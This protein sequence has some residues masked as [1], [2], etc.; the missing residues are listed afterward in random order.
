MNSLEVSLEISLEISLR[1]CLSWK[2]L[3]GVAPGM[4]LM[5]LQELSWNFSQEFFRDFSWSSFWDWGLKEDLLIFLMKLLPRF[6]KDVPDFSKYL[7]L[8]FVS[9]ILLRFFGDF[10]QIGPRALP[11]VPT[12][13]CPKTSFFQFFNSCFPSSC[14][15]FPRVYLG[16]SP[17]LTSINY[18]KSRFKQET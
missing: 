8:E 2:T 16:I 6:F 13:N 10:V 18:Y 11:G 15:G 3:P 14:R 9:V 1:T 5:A 7:Y 17:G 4:S 12:G